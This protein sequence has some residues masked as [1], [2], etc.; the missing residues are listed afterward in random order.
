MCI[1]AGIPA[2]VYFIRTSG[3]ADGPGDLPVRG[4]RRVMLLVTVAASIT[5]QPAFVSNSALALGFCSAVFSALALV[6]LEQSLLDLAEA[7]TMANVA[8]L[9]SDWEGEEAWRNCATIG[10]E[11]GMYLFFGFA[12]ASLVFESSPLRIWANMGVY[13]QKALVLVKAGWFSVKLIGIG[14]LA[15]GK[16][17]VVPF[18]V[19]G[20]CSVIHVRGHWKLR[21]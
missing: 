13:D 15:A 19:S 18:V 16:W 12:G 3:R 20:S 10:R 2:A 14:L 21:V 6:L 4:M 8:P 17:A 11:V 5:L 7:G 9:R 1:K